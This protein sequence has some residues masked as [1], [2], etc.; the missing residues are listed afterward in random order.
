[1]EICFLPDLAGPVL[2]GSTLSTIKIYL[3]LMIETYLYQQADSKT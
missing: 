3:F 1:M 2:S